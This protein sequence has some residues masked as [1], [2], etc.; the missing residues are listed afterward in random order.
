MLIPAGATSTVITI[1]TQ[2]D[3]DTEEELAIW[4]LA[5][6]SGTAAVATDPY[7][8]RIIDKDAGSTP[9]IGTPVFNYSSGTYIGPITVLADIDPSYAGIYYMITEAALGTDPVEPESPVANGVLRPGVQT[10]STLGL[11]CNVGME[12][13][14]RAV[15][16]MPG[17]DRFGPLAELKLRITDSSAFIFAG[18]GVNAI[19]SRVSPACIEGSTQA[20]GFNIAQ[21]NFVALDPVTDQAIASSLPTALGL[22][23]YYT[24]LKLFNEVDGNNQ[25]LTKVQQRYRDGT[26]LHV[27]ATQT[28]EWIV[29]DLA[30]LNVLTIRR[31]DTLLVTCSAGSSRLNLE[32]G[33]AGNLALDPG[34]VVPLTFPDAGYFSLVA[35]ENGQQRAQMQVAVLGYQPTNEIV[36]AEIGFARE[37]GVAVE[38]ADVIPGL[39]VVTQGAAAQPALGITAGQDDELEVAVTQLGYEHVDLTVKPLPL[40]KP[41]DLFRRGPKMVLRAGGADGDVIAAVEITDFEVLLD[42]T[43]VEASD[44]TF[45]D[46]VYAE[47]VVV[48]RP[49]VPVNVLVSDDLNWESTSGSQPTLFADVGGQTYPPGVRQ[50][51]KP[52]LRQH[53]AALD[54]EVEI[55]ATGKMEGTVFHL[56][57]ALTT[58]ADANGDEDLRISDRVDSL[59]IKLYEPL[60]VS[61]SLTVQPSPSIDLLDSLT[62]RGGDYHSELTGFYGGTIE[63]SDPDRDGW[64]VRDLLATGVLET[65]NLPFYVNTHFLTGD[66]GLDYSI[67]IASSISGREPQQVS[68]HTDIYFRLEDFT[69]P[70]YDA[71]ILGYQD[72]YGDPLYIYPY[73]DVSVDEDAPDVEV[74]V[75]IYGLEEVGEGDMQHLPGA[76]ML[77]TRHDSRLTEADV[78][79]CGYLANRGWEH[80]KAGAYYF[81]AD[82][83]RVVYFEGATAG[84]KMLASNTLEVWGRSGGEDEYDV[85]TVAFRNAAGFARAYS[86]GPNGAIVVEINGS[87]SAPQATLT[88][89]HANVNL[90]DK[91]G[92]PVF[93]SDDLQVTVAATRSPFTPQFLVDGELTVKV[94][95]QGIAGE[96]E[97]FDFFMVT[98]SQQGADGY[99]ATVRLNPAGV[100]ADVVTGNVAFSRPIRVQGGD[101]PGP[102]LAVSYN[103]LDG[104]DVGW[105]SGWRTNYDLRVL[106][107]GAFWWLIDEIGTREKTSGGAYTPIYLHEQNERVNEG[108]NYLASGPYQAGERHRITR[109]DGWTLY[110]NGEGFLTRKMSLDGHQITVVRHPDDP[111]TLINESRVIDKVLSG[112]G[113][114]VGLEAFL[115][116][117]QASGSE[118]LNAG[119]SGSWSF[120]YHGATKHGVIDT[121]TLTGTDDT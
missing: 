9:V 73:Y 31:G 111:Q 102:D 21:L 87:P 120:T 84:I 29:S 70:Y 78:F 24:D 63:R 98:D 66:T 5:L 55:A 11:T 54:R 88:R 77:Q 121:I 116:A 105:G 93:V 2:A 35:T 115:G 97:V 68:T 22:K 108:G 80:A 58:N 59:G 32:T 18:G 14:I 94:E 91:D 83:P 89:S 42:L 109:R 114:E 96:E 71:Q 64:S 12:Y 52:A 28:Y 49:A 57:M 16:K 1:A 37:H 104:F 3:A 117:F 44:D 40:K 95:F 106:P 113:R 45:S 4:N 43:V 47:D 23:T 50:V 39:S 61:A 103:S 118:D 26:G 85:G 76:G 53:D 62:I 46:D 90:I 33:I 41:E 110:F 17:E 56:W 69:A 7:Q 119:A 8:L 10:W 36:A 99:G 112:D 107:S 72:E 38:G 92:W 6:V 65:L 19:P 34:Q 86:S 81:L 79:R 27:L 67:G 51:S 48:I 75:T 100:T 74:S 82:G 20:D 60:V 101:L 13:H 25:R 30:E 15:A